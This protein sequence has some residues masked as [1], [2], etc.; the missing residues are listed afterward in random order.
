MQISSVEMSITHENVPIE[1][2]KYTIYIPRERVVL[3]K[4]AF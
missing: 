2:V 1:Q 3:K 4:L